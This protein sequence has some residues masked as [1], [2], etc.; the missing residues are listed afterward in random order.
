MKRDCGIQAAFFCSL[1]ADAGPL[2]SI[3][4]DMPRERINAV[5]NLMRARSVARS[6]ETLRQTAISA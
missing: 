1:L 5:T 3:A 2:R 4:V 6:D